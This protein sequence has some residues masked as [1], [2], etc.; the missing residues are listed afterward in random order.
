MFI[1]YLLRK[2]FSLPSS[3]IRRTCSRVDVEAAF[4]CT[5]GKTRT[6]GIYFPAFSQT[7]RPPNARNFFFNFVTTVVD[8]SVTISVAIIALSVYK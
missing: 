8:D 4:A 6:L 1:K 2:V 3:F 7:C 5:G